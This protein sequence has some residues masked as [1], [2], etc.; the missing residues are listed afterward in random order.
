MAEQVPQ[1]TKYRERIVREDDLLNSRTVLF[2][3]T[4][5]LLLTAVGL[6]GDPLVR[7]L[8]CILGSIITIAWL[9]T[10][11][12]NWRV[13]WALTRS[14]R[15]HWASD[16]FEDIVQ[17]ALFKPGWKRPTALIAIAIPWVF[18]IVWICIL[19]LSV[20]RFLNPIECECLATNA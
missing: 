12:Q 18:Q 5:G 6:G 13:I 1:A 2:L 4:N 17:G 9:M 7:I 20:W 14:Y 10:S 8:I 19:A 15:K 11:Y 16:H 3:V